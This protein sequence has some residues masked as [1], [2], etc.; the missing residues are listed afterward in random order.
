[1]TALGCGT[2]WR[3]GLVGVGTAFSVTLGMGFKTLVLAAWKL[4]FSCLPSEQ[5]VQC[6]ALHRPGLP[7]CCHAPA[8]M[9]ME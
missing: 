1:M 7:K 5:D 4:V 9:I 6:S 3:C 2:I 8:L